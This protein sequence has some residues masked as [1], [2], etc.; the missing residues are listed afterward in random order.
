MGEGVEVGVGVGAVVVTRI[1]VMFAIEG[2]VQAIP[3]LR[4]VML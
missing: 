4:T 1:K 3:A 2:P